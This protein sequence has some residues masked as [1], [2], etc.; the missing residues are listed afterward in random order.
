MLI[1]STENVQ[2]PCVIPQGISRFSQ[3][4]QYELDVSDDMANSRLDKFVAARLPDLSR[5]RIK[6]LIDEQMV[7]LNGNASKPSAQVRAGD[8]VRVTIPELKPPSYEPEEIPLNVLF[9][10]DAVIVLN[11]PPGLVVHPGA[12]NMT[13][14]LVNALL[15]YADDLSG[16][17]G[18]ERPGIVHRLDKDTSGCLVVAKHDVAHRALAGQFAGRD[19]SKIYIA[20]ATGVPKAPQGRI[21]ARIGRHPVD[22]KKMAVVKEPAGREATT[23]YR[24]VQTL[25]SWSVI[26]CRLLTGRTH[27]IRVHLKHL[28]HPLAGDTL[29]GGKTSNQIA[30]QMLHAW[31]LGFF[32]PIGQNWMEFEAPLPDDFTSLGVLRPPTT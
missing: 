2:S 9:E 24:V 29:Y 3:M 17:G 31:R 18:E 21:D 4:T 27:Q 11:K 22:R 10:D 5:S 26:V 14:T 19:V 32:H 7:Y 13:H 25:A 30:R 23:E 1:T 16:I 20:V 15:H 6:S 12:G 28:G 8:S